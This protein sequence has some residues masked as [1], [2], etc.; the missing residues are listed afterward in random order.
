MSASTGRLTPGCTCS[1]WNSCQGNR[2]SSA[3]ASV[4][5]SPQ[6]DC[7]LPSAEAMALAA[8]VR[9]VDCYTVGRF[10]AVSVTYDTRSEHDVMWCAI[11][12]L[13][14]SLGAAGFAPR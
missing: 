6:P 7:S 11:T 3:S 10:C 4:H 2:S 5:E 14:Q 8:F 13:R 1:T 9:R 12:T